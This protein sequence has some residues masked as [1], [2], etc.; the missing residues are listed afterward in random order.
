MEVISDTILFLG[1]PITESHHHTI[2]QLP[3]AERSLFINSNPLYL[4]QIEHEGIV[5]LGKS[6]GVSMEINQLEMMTTNILS[7]LKKLIPNHS[8]VSDS[9]VLLALPSPL[10]PK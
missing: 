10:L 3:D 5:Y 1:F 9:L 2:K 7:L 4:E 8:Y 6:L